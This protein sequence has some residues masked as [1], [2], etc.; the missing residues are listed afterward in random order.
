MKNTSKIYTYAALIAGL[1]LYILFIFPYLNNIVFDAVLHYS[2]A[3]RFMEGRP[4]QFNL[5]EINNASSSPFW[6]ILSII[7]MKLAGYEYIILIKIFVLTAFFFTAYLLYITG[8]DIWKFNGFMKYTPVIAWFFTISILRN[9]LSGMEN[10]LSACQ[11]LLLY[12]SICKS[13]NTISN[14]KPYLIGLLTGWI[15][16]TRLEVGVISIILVVLYYFKLLYY[17]NIKWK[18]AL[19]Y[20]AVLIIMVLLVQ[21][22]WY[23]YQYQVTGKILS[24]SMTSRIYLGRWLSVVII[25]KFLYYHPYLTFILCSVYLPF[26]IGL[27]YKVWKLRSHVK[28]LFKNILSYFFGNFGKSIALLVFIYGFVFYTFIVGGTQIGRYFIPYL[29]SL[30]LLGISGLSDMYQL[31]KKRNFV[32]A[33]IFLIIV[34]SYFV[35]L[36]GKQYYIKVFKGE[37]LEASVNEM[38]TAPENRTAFTSDFLRKCNYNINDTIKLATTETHFKYYADDRINLMSLDGRTSGKIFKYVD[39]DG[40]P[41]LE[42]FILDEKPDLIDVNLWHDLLHGRYILR[43][44]YSF[45]KY[46]IK[47]NI[48]SEWEY[49]TQR[50]ALGDKFYWNGKEVYLAA[51][52]GYVKVIWNK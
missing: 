37:N 12:Y 29:F 10:V 50:M 21:F 23:M 35:Y 32:I 47:D 45:I 18:Q 3:E 2:F 38:I 15:I 24:D 8:R 51:A 6:T 17:K 34:V 33:Q 31:V 13:E 42:K 46:G 30:F 28:N 22:P 14:L 43:E 4:F 40:F 36:N 19:Y 48:L 25:K 49:K 16:L 7:S 44:K 20:F 27:L 9:A 1:A 11:V 41:D 26:F 52:P 5:N 39:D